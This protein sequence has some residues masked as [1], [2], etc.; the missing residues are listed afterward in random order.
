MAKKKDQEEVIVDVKEVYTKTELFVDRNR[1]ML[2]GV[3]VVIVAVIAVGAAYFYLMVK[4]KEQNANAEAWKA[5]QYFQID[6]LDLALYGDGLYAGLEDIMDDHDGTKA[7]A[8][9]HYELGIIARDRGNFEEAIAHFNQVSFDDE[10]VS[11]LAVG[12]IGDC[13][14]ELGN[15]AE[16]AKAFEKAAAKGRGSNAEGFTVPMML[17]KAGITY[18]ELGQNEDAAKQFEKIVE[19]YPESQVFGGAQRY[20]AYLGKK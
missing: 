19:N 15:Y 16:A 2:T 5:E 13:E 18:M 6:S 10:V 7:A 20:A 1:K 3:L 9:A 12:A 14:V 11:V 4:P 8:R 17:Y